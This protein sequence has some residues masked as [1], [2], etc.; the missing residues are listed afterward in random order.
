MQMKNLII[1]MIICILVNVAIAEGEETV[2]F[3]SSKLE[4]IVCQKL[5]VEPPVNKTK[6]RELTSLHL[7]EVAGVNDLT[8]IEYA[9]SLEGLL[10]YDNPIRDLSPL[11]NLKMLKGIQIS[12]EY[13]EDISPL[14]ALTNLECLS[15][16]DAPITDISPLAG[17]KNLED[18][19]LTKNRISDISP[20]SK[21][22]NLKRLTII[23]NQ[24]NYKPLWSY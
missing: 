1:S 11:S 13:I 10:I 22:V 14:A 4:K 7:D 2:H 16:S 18:L 6:M 15:L 20:L 24:K 23:Y 12:G 17:L 21:L 5:G 8:G 19:N 9:T 3:A